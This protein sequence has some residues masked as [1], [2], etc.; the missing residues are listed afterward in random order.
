MKRTVSGT[1][2]HREFQVEEDAWQELTMH[3]KSLRKIYEREIDCE[4]IVRDMEDRIG[5]HP[6]GMARRARKGH[7]N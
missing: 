1:I 3:L 6:L 7:F 5:E 4:E 2:G